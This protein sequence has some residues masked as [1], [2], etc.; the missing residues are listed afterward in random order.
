MSAR[1][2]TYADYLIGQRIRLARTIMEQSQHDFAVK[3][4]VSVRWTPFVGQ[5]CGLDK[6][7]SGFG[8]QAGMSHCM[9]NFQRAALPD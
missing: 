9:L 7:V 3:L 4:G 6:L 8:F 2:S 5:V 1:K